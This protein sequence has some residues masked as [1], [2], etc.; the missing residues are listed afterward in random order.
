MVL[1]VCSTCS[2]ARSSQLFLDQRYAGS[3]PHSVGQLTRGELEVHNTP[4]CRYERPSRRMQQERP[5]PERA[6][7]DTFGANS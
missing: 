2:D 1:R 5:H 6:S 3:E 4:M 7:R